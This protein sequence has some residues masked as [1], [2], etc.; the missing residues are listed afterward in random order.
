MHDDALAKDAETRAKKA[1][2][3]LARE[4]W[5]SQ[6]HYLAFGLTNEGK[7]ADT[8]GS[9][10]AA[11]LALSNGFDEP[12]AAEQA[13]TYAKPDLAS[14]W[15][16]RT[17]STNDAVFDP[18]SYHNG[19]EWPVMQTYVALAEFRHGASLPAFA[20]LRN[21]AN[22]TGIQAPGW[23]PE[24][25]NGERF[26][27][28]ERSVPHQLFSS[29]GVIVPVITGMLGIETA[30]QVALHPA[31][32]VEWRKMT[33]TGLRLGAATISGHLLQPDPGSGGLTLQFA[34]G[35]AHVPTLQ[36]QVPFLSKT[37]AI[38]LVVN[39]SG[40]IGVVVPVGDPEPGARSSALKIIHTAESSD[41]KTVEITVAGLG[42][43]T[44]SLDLRT[45]FPRLSVNGAQVQ[46]TPDGF[47][48]AISFEGNGWIEKKLVV[49]P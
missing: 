13:Q 23:M 3:S 20:D 25:M 40:G 48:L 29:V 8:S 11:L 44:Y 42:G 17:L 49:R 7:R 35:Q 9:W 31:F 28:G 38:P 19:T 21:T 41:R 26:L 45:A 6:G 4:W 47:R 12:K 36:A 46:K 5:N 2:E 1:N 18:T 30:P 34:S 15:G 22:L 14:D 32:P 39:W 43:H 27:A 16:T 37:H 33:F 24:H 10:S